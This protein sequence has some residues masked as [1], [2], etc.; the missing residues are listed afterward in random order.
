MSL[1]RN[2]PSVDSDQ[3]IPLDMVISNFKSALSSRRPYVIKAIWNE[4]PLLQAWYGGEQVNFGNNDLG[5]ADVRVMLLDEAISHFKSALSSRASYAIKAIWNGNPL[6]RAWYSG[7]QVNFG[8]NG[9][10][11][12]DLRAIS[13]D[14]LVM[15]FKSALFS[16]CSDIIKDMWNGN[17]LLQ[18]W[19]SGQRVNFGNNDEGES[20]VRAISLDVLISCFKAALSSRASYVIKAMWYRNERLHHAIQ[21][22]PI[23]EAMKLLKNVMTSSKN[24]QDN[25][26]THYVSWVKHVDLIKQALE[27]I[28]KKEGKSGSTYKANRIAL[29]ENR[30]AELQEN[31]PNVIDGIS[32]IALPSSTKTADLVQSSPSRKEKISSKEEGVLKKQKTETSTV[33]SNSSEYT[34]FGR[35]NVYPLSGNSNFLRQGEEFSDKLEGKQHVV[36][37]KI[38]DDRVSTLNCEEEIFSFDY[39]FNQ[40]ESNRDH[41]SSFIQ[42]EIDE[43]GESLLVYPLDAFTEA[44]FN[45]TYD[46]SDV[47]TDIDAELRNGEVDREEDFSFDYLF[48]RDEGNRDNGSSFTQEKK[49]EDDKPLLIYPLNA[50]NGSAF[51]ATYNLSDVTTDAGTELR[52]GEVDTVEDFSFNYLF[53]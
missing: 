3:N 47:A 15:H 49:C 35:G 11:E 31:T 19:Y 36:E 38:S 27:D 52:N 32:V 12:S 13:L 30:L 6:F 20:D 50:F 25:F 51:N 18:V 34:F 17:P 14:D 46:L 29:L 43:E 22:L 45:T 40:E 10:G 8:N 33:L 48:N 7:R 9:L 16:R 4:N 5:Q 24:C 1:T 26:I 53:S 41:G 42:E 39:L 44:P 2:L 28:K 23:S 37:R 21:S